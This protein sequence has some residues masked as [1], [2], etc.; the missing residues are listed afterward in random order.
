M[1][2]DQPRLM[3]HSNIEINK[4]IRETF[5]EK[6][7]RENKER[8]ENDIKLGRIL[9]EDDYIKIKNIIVV[10]FT[11]RNEVGKLTDSFIKSELSIVIDHAK[12]KHSLHMTSPH[13]YD[14]TLMI[15]TIVGKNVDNCKI[16]CTHLFWFDL[17]DE[18][19]F[20][21]LLQ[22]LQMYLILY[23]PGCL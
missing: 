22:T 15:K 7:E 3:D 17:S 16:Q 14:N 6:L 13:S 10:N 20:Q 4:C 1:T 21:K 2:I 12:R 19:V 11:E 9:T 5:I 8:R 18:Y 23:D